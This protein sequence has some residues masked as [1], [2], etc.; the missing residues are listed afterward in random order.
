VSGTAISRAG[1][2]VST[3]IRLIALFTITAWSAMNPNTPINNGSRNSAPP[4]PIIPP[5]TPI[6][7]P[8]ANGDRDRSAALTASGL[9]LDSAT[10]P[11]HR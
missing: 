6:K 9:I 1:S 7:P 3:T 8:A 10:S 5:S 11:P 2:A 4:S